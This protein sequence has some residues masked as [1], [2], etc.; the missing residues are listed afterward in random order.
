[1]ED[2]NTSQRLE[3]PSNYNAPLEQSR[4][5]NKITNSKM[6]E[7]KRRPNKP[8]SKVVITYTKRRRATNKKSQQVL[9]KRNEIVWAIWV[10]RD[11]SEIQT[12]KTR[13]ITE[14]DFE[15]SSNDF[16]DT[17]EVIS[18]FLMVVSKDTVKGHNKT[19]VSP[20][21][22]QSNFTSK[23]PKSPNIKTD[24]SS[25]L[26]NHYLLRYSSYE[27]NVVTK[28]VYRSI[29]RLYPRT[30]YQA[31]FDRLLFQKKCAEQFLSLQKQKVSLNIHNSTKYLTITSNKNG[32]GCID[33]MPESDA[34][35]ISKRGR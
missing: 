3:H 13:P 18:A 28:A 22:N 25:R 30:D 34:P 23:M 2:T 7:Y 1:M 24:S 12:V 35:P 14:H 26:S 20:I 31:Y 8:Q 15:K 4:C 16:Q 33:L 9:F 6:G 19:S 5:D 29:E 11:G 32:S 21:D 17:H 27:P 10:E